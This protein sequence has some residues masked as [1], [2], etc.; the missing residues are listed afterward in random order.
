MAV[1]DHLVELQMRQ[2]KE[3]C[4]FAKS[5]ARQTRRP[6]Y[7]IL[8]DDSQ[9]ELSCCRDDLSFAGLYS[10]SLGVRRRSPFRFSSA[11]AAAISQCSQR[12]LPCRKDFEP[13]RHVRFGS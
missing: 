1:T 4:N 2:T 7:R 3:A 8:E 5:I 9:W 6:Q 12:M 13:A 10:V 11:R